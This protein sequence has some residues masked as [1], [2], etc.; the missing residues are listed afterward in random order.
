MDLHGRFVTLI[1]SYPTHNAPA[2]CNFVGV[3]EVTTNGNPSGNGCDFYRELPQS[4]GKI[5][6][7]S[8]AFH[9][10]AKGKDYFLD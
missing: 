1:I 9:G 3:F 2:E 4:L 8:V 7:R 10:R 6:G 5:K